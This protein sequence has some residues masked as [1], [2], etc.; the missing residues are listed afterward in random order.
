M[1]ICESDAH[2]DELQAEAWEADKARIETIFALVF[3]RVART[4]AAAEMASS[5]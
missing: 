5:V 2:A 1:L 4:T 3:D